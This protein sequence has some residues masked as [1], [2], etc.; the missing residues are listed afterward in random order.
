M[1]M[2]LFSLVA[3]ASLNSS[4]AVQQRQVMGPV[5]VALSDNFGAQ[6]RHAVGPSIQNAMRS[7]HD[8]STAVKARHAVA[9][10]EE[11]AT[12]SVQ[13]IDLNESF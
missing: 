8:I 3:L 12:Q 1:K 6:Q 2:I 11:N 10:T 4:A 9:K 5:R 13:K 7:R